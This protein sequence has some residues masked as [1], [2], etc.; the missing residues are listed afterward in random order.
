MMLVVAVPID[1]RG[2]CVVSRLVSL[3]GPLDRVISVYPTYV[4]PKTGFIA[5][6][7]LVDRPGLEEALADIDGSPFPLV[8]KKA[9]DEA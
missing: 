7:A 8:K 6:E 4:D 2:C 5:L 9:P 1:G 3:L